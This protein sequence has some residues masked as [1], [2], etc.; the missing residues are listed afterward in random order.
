MSQHGLTFPSG[1]LTLEGVLHLPT[2]EPSPYP[3]VV[4]CHPHP[5]YGGDMHNNVVMAIVSGLVERGVAALRFNFR[6]VGESTGAH[7]R[8][9]GELDD[10]AAALACMRSGGTR[11]APSA[12]PERQQK[13][14]DVKRIGLA[15]YSFGA[16]MAL[17][18]APRD[19]GLAAL[20][21]VAPPTTALNQPAV[22]AWAKPKLILA[23]DMDTF[24]RVEEIHELS[25]KRMAQPLAIEV[26][27]GAD[28]F[29]VGYERQ[30]AEKVG[31]FFATLLCHPESFGGR[32]KGLVLQGD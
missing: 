7:G 21:V 24:F 25:R 28:H 8:G 16:G 11:S 2:G 13:Q 22:L 10:V 23:G 26:L 32:T 29:M 27:H 3:G 30:I 1:S 20:A 12:A 5:L 17:A 15:G 31:A 19:T 14:I 6:G 18:A 4:V 9:Q